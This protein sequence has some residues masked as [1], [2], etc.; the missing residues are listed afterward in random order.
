[1]KENLM[2]VILAK[3]QLPR[4]ISKS[5]TAL[6]ASVSKRTRLTRKDQAF[7]NTIESTFRNPKLESAFKHHCREM[8]QEADDESIVAWKRRIGLS[9]IELIGNADFDSSS[10][11]SEVLDDVLLGTGLEPSSDLRISRKLDLPSHLLRLCET[12]LLTPEE[13]WQLFRRMN[14]LRH[15]AIKFRDRL[16]ESVPSVVDRRRIE[17]LLT[18]SNWYRDLIVKSNMRLVISI[19]KKFVN[20]HNTFD[21]LLSD[22]IIALMRA[23][24]KFD[25]DRGF[26]FSTYAT[27]VVRRNAYRMVM[28]KQKDRAH[29]ATSLHDSGIEV[30]ARDE[31]STL[32]IDRWNDL[33]DRLG[34]L[35]NQL[36]RREKLIIRARF[37]LG[38]HRRIQTLQYLADKLGVSKERVRQLEKRALDRLREMASQVK[39][40]EMVL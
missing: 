31:N 33:R 35:L 32:S 14:F 40:P 10:A 36:D 37:S 24:D 16:I 25:Y 20:S 29:I 17:G 27:Q 23:V 26:R 19:V 7:A 11:E 1:M 38:S 3:K 4:T 15:M 6:P 22:G 2:A 13:E 28:T 18:A 21:E 39:L 12:G 8:I 5:A 9:D 34:V 30:C